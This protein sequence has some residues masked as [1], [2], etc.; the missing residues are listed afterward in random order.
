MYKVDQAGM[1]VR[2]WLRSPRPVP[3][4]TQ[5]SSASQTTLSM[6]SPRLQ[7]PPFCSPTTLSYPLSWAAEA[8]TNSAPVGATPVLLSQHTSV[9]RLCFLLNSFV[10]LD[11]HDVCRFSAGMRYRFWVQETTDLIWRCTS[12]ALL[13]SVMKS[14][15]SR[16]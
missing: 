4:T 15:L 14:S 10:F 9:H 7:S 12:Y 2:T 11:I 8:S 1:R 6:F 13:N 3:P 5:A 16:L